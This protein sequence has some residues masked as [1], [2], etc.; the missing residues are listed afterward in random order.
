MSE[1]KFIKLGQDEYSIVGELTFAGINKNTLKSLT[2]MQGLKQIRFDLNK[3]SAI[4]SAG[5]AFMLECIQRCQ[6][7]Q[8]RL[9]FQNIPP[10]L[11]A[12]AKLSGL[13]DIEYFNPVSS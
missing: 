2:F 9:K 5:L 8:T 13:D 7:Q 1:L 12:L 3:V 10:Q 6:Q 4:D 11:L